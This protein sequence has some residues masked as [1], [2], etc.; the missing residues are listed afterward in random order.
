[1]GRI[2]PFLEN[3]GGGW[4]MIFISMSKWRG[5]PT[6]ENIETTNKVLAS[7]PRIKVLGFYWTL[8][9]YDSILITEAPNEKTMLKTLLEVGAYVTTE[10]M[11]AI[12]REEA[13]KLL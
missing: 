9:R 11:V 1:M 5:K 6:K 4:E 7:E 10:T 2:S 12:S 3:K 13:I 8:G